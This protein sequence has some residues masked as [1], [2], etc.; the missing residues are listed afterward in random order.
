MNEI[1]LNPD[2]ALRQWCLERA[3]ETRALTSVAHM[4][5]TNLAEDYYLWIT[6]GK[7]QSNSIAEIEA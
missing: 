3:F 6:E 1:T 4:E 7:S 5:V 2:C